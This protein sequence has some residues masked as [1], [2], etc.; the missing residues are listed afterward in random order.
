MEL[1]QRWVSARPKSITA[2]RRAGRILSIMDRM[3]A[4]MDIADTVSKSGW[5]LSRSE[6]PK[7]EQILKRSITLSTKC[8]EWYVAMQ[9][10]ALD[11]SWESAA[12]QA[13]LSRPSNLSPLIITTIAC[14][15]TRFC[16]SGAERRE[17]EKFLQELPTT[18]EETQVTFSI[19]GV[20]GTLV[21]GC[22][23]DQHLNLSWPRIQRGLPQSRRR[24]AHR[25]RTGTCL[26]TWP[27]PSTILTLR[28]KCLPGSGTN[29]ARIPG[30]HPPTLSRPSNGRNNWRR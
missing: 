26:P 6:P 12:R 9:N 5:S 3:R 25:P 10:V 19:S 23:N 17:V 29:G 13:L 1:V 7:Q 20:A 16:R 22:D 8:P 21:C 27:S 18:S 2:P 30:G 14:M 11:Q 4:A 28:T 15:R 24:T